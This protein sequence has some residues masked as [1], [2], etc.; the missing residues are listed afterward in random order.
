MEFIDLKAQY[1]ASRELINSRIQAVLDHGQYIMGPEVAELEARLARYT[2]ARHC[3]T[4]ASGTEA[5][6]ISLMALGIRPGDEVITT[7]FSFIATAEAIVLVGATP[8]FVD[9]DRATCNLAPHLI[10]A[11]VTP[12]TRAIMPVSLFGQPADMDEINAIAA[13]HGLAV[14]EDAAQSFGASYRGKK[15]CNLSTVGCTSFFPSKPLGCYGDGGAIFTSDDELAGA[16]REIRVHGQS[17][18]YVHTRIGVGGRMDTLQCAVVLAKLER[19]EWELE[20]RARVA[21][22][23]NAMLSGRIGLVA[24]MPGRTSVYA[25]YTAVVEERERIQAT[26]HAAGIPTAVHYPVPIP[27]QGAYAHL[28]SP[29]CCPVALEMAARVISLPMGPYLS[30]ESANTVAAA[31][32]QAAGVALPGGTGVA[33]GREAPGIAAAAPVLP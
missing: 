30:A 9:I 4:V 22:R 2:G 27:M 12:R 13:R 7:P 24:R 17:R 1:E 20:Q 19:F 29:D 31:L 3:I 26:L 18:R 28:S 21:A 23:Y 14:I 25:Q 8:V 32:L 11:K 6:V 5:L 15:S 10:E 16:M 33:E